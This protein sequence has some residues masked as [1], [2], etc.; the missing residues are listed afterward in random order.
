[1]KVFVTGG[2]GYVGS[3][4]LRW[5]ARHGHEVM[6]YDNLSEGNEA[7]VE[8]GRLVVGDLQD[9][10]K[11]TQVLREFRPDAVMHF[12]ALASVPDS[13]KDPESYYRINVDGTKNLLDAML[14]NGIKRIVFS[15]TAATYSFAAEM[16]LRE[17]SPQVPEVPYGRSKL[18]AEF[19]IR[20]YCRAYD[21]GFTIFRYFNASGAD[22]DGRH[23][24]ARK[25][26]GHLIP[27]ALSVAVGVREKLMVF[28]SDYPTKDGSC[29]RDYVHTADL[30]SAHQLAVESLQPG[31]QRFYNLGSGVGVTV[32]E[33][34]Q[35]CQKVVGKPIRHDVVA[36]RPGDPAVL[37]ASDESIRKDLNWRPRH[38]I[39][40][41]VSSAWKWHQGHPHGY[42]AH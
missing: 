34:L 18:A 13:I 42:V 39:D 41:I 3:A 26:E 1:M 9:R 30:A 37:I 8:G 12:A 29:V 40:E 6:A 16:P 31:M 32:F 11:M 38:G 23:G 28:G 20:D 22:L 7:A 25:H 15:S 36:R 4:C 24:E 17:T 35:A 27:L 21:V 14:E 2:A 19:L 5:L 10:A 33:V